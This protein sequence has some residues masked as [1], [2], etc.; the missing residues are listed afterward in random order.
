MNWILISSPNCC[1]FISILVKFKSVLK[2]SRKTDINVVNTC[3]RNMI[4]TLG[5]AHM[6]HKCCR[7]LRDEKSYI[8][9]FLF[10]FITDKNKKVCM[11]LLIFSNPA[12][13][14]SFYFQY[15]CIFLMLKYIFYRIKDKTK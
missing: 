8:L 6:S 14:G 11:M 9:V 7:F 13:F 12:G 5:S 15:I 1:Q 3:K 4:G 10:I 2:T